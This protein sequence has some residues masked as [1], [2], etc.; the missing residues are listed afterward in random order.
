MKVYNPNEGGKLMKIKEYHSVIV[1]KHPYAET[2]NKKLM[3]EADRL[4]FYTPIDNRNYTNIRG[5]QYNFPVGTEPEGVRTVMKWVDGLCYA[6]HFMHRTAL[7][8]HN[9]LHVEMA[10]WFAKYEEKQYTI[11]HDHRSDL[12]AFVYFVNTPKGSSPLI[13]TTSGKKIKAEAGKIVVFPGTIRHCV[14]K[15]NCKNRLVL[16]GN[17]I[18]K[19]T[20]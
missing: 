6:N 8:E 10:V 7:V 18:F 12:L 1:D 20:T 17:I 13:F 5:S 11:D 9:L 16:A 3:D 2:L 15:N 19:H 14:P 4:D